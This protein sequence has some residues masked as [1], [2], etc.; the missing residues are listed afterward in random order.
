[1]SR[2]HLGQTEISLYLTGPS[3]FWIN[4]QEGAPFFR[5][6]SS[7]VLTS[8]AR[9]GILAHGALRSSEEKSYQKSQVQFLTTHITTLVL[10]S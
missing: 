2:F 6:Q 10:R 5:A 4:C 9:A 1:M 8:P 7:E 3:L